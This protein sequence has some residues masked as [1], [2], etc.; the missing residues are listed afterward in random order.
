[1][2][3]RLS[4]SRYKSAPLTLS[5]CRKRANKGDFW[6]RETSEQWWVNFV[7][8]RQS[9]GRRWFQAAC[10][11]GMSPSDHAENLIGTLTEIRLL[12]LPV[13]T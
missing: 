6:R 13:F 10:K 7:T 1:M 9:C 5:S 12:K 3:C 2:I 4:F 8:D 11:L